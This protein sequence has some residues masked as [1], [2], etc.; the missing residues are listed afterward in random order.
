MNSRITD[1]FTTGFFR[2]VNWPNPPQQIEFARLNLTNTVMSKRYL[3]AMVDDGTVEGWDDPRMPTIA[4]LRRRGYTPESIRDF[5]ER[6]GVSKANS[7]VDVS[8]LEHCVK[9]GSQGQGCIKKCCR[10]SD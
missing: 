3:K 8:L 1:L 5:C 4:G 9:R 10:G 6:I 2:S 7:T